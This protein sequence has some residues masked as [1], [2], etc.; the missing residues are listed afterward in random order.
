MNI[1][2]HT[3]SLQLR[4]PFRISH[5]MRTAQPT[6]IV[7]LQKDGISGYGEATATSYYGLTI[8][9]MVATMKAVLPDLAKIPLE[10]PEQYYQDI[11][12]ILTRH[13][14]L[15][16]ALDVAA[17]DLWGKIQDTPLHQL[18][19]DAHPSIPMTNYTIGLGDLPEVLEKIAAFPWP[20]YKIKLGGQ[21]DIGTIAAI[22]KATSAKLRV[23]A[24]TGWTPSNALELINAMA[25]S[26]VEMIEQPLPVAYDSTMWK[27]KAYTTIPFIADESCQTE[28]DVEKCAEGFDGINIKLMK[29]GG[30]TPARRMIQKAQKLGLQIMVGCMTESS[31][32]IAAIAQLLPALDYVDMDGPLLIQNDPGLPLTMTH[33]KVTLP[34]GPGTGAVLLKNHPL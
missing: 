21:D 22:R 6:L 16:C 24:N 23:D 34:K 30:L 4:T 3:F 25:A 5:G 2:L 17:N 8:D 27:L 12:P 26:G 15:R 29:C 32:G 18:W 9:N 33:G 20:I 14:F 7:E 10:H 28:E 11:F 13:P 19:W 1:Q 31:I